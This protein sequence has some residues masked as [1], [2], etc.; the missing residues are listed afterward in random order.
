[1]KL[2]IQGNSLRLRLS[3]SEV[4]RFNE[5]LIIEDTVDFG[6]STLTY[7]LSVSHNADAVSAKYNGDIIEVQVPAALAQ[8]WAGTEQV[9]IAAEQ[10]LENGTRLQ[11][12]IEK[13]FKCAHNSQ[14]ANADAYLN[15]LA[16][17]RKSAD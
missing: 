15:P 14:D 16:E 1:M 6:T 3:R 5:K 9:S 7:L 11:L 13:D 12:L 10:K 2:R 17:D 8:D 4:M